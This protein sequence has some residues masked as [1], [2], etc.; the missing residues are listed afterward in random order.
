M[1]GL[2][3]VQVI[4]TGRLGQKLQAALKANEKAAVRALNSVAV[5]ARG[6]ASK[7]MRQEIRFKDAYIKSRTSIT[8]ARPG[9]LTAVITAR[10]RGTRLDRFASN[11]SKQRSGGRPAKVRIKTRGGSKL[12]KGGFYVPLK[13]GRSAH[14]A[15]GFGIARRLTRGTG[16]GR[17]Y[18]V[19]HTVSVHDAYEDVKPSVERMVKPILSKRFRRELN[20]ALGKLSK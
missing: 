12:V 6:E 5:T 11:P 8:R 4:N 9:K 18:K 15:N 19:L 7:Q 14:G 3:K 17:D 13:R 2:L 1:A 16:S 20:F 10:F